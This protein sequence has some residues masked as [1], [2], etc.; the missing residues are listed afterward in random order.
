M[1]GIITGIW[2]GE[3]GLVLKENRLCIQISQSKLE[4]YKLDVVGN[5]THCVSF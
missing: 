3:E 5:F 2:M 1:W 4:F